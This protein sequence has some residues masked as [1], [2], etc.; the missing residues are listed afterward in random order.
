MKNLSYDTLCDAV[1]SFYKPAEVGKANDLL[2]QRFPGNSPKRVKHRKT[3]DIIQSTYELMQ[4]LP[5]EDPP[6]FGT[7]DLK[8]IP[9]PN[10]SNI[11]GAALVRQQKSVK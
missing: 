2:F 5:T 4:A 10:L 11:E 3:E 9:L 8:N 7:T 6:V 1:Q